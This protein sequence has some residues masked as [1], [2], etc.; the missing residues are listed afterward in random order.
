MELHR[1]L[2]GSG[3]VVEVTNIVDALFEGQDK[4]Q[5]LSGCTSLF[6][7]RSQELCYSG[8]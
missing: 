1:Y 2:L 4:S 7:I 6:F 3:F 8:N 5:K